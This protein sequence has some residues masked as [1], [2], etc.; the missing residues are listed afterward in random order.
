MAGSPLFKR[1]TDLPSH[2]CSIIR[3]L[4]SVCVM[5]FFPQRLPTFTIF[6]LGLASETIA[7]GH[8]IVV[9]HDVRA[10]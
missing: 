2:A 6:A 9:Q 3:K 10:L 8:E 1:T 7:S 5:P 4:I